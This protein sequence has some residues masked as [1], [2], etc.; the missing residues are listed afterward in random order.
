MDVIEVR[1]LLLRTVLDEIRSTLTPNGAVRLAGPIE[2]AEGALGRAEEEMLGALIRGVKYEYYAMIRQARQGPRAEQMRRVRS[3]LEK[4]VLAAVCWESKETQLMTVCRL[5]RAAVAAGMA[6]GVPEVV[7]LAEVDDQLRGAA[8][9]SAVDEMLAAA[10]A[11]RGS[12][13]QL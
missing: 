9:A 7:L 10:A 6:R 3:V 12:T 1:E 4:A 11:L 8:L 5:A 2:A 13:S